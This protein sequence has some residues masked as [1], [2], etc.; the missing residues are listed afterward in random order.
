[1]R[2]NRPYTYEEYKDYIENSQQ[3]QFNRLATFRRAGYCCEWCGASNVSLHCHHTPEA[4]AYPLG[5]ERIEDLRAVCGDCHAWY[6]NKGG[7][8]PSKLKNT[9]IPP[10]M[11][12]PEAITFS[13]LE[14]MLKAFNLKFGGTTE[15]T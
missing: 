9:K 15:T 1:M 6:H 5:Q 3:W 7:K 10:D 11:I 2:F 8:L 12:N 14:D 13:Q 4:Y